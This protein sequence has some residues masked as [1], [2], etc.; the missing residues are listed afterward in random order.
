MRFICT[1]LVS[2]IALLH[3]AAATAQSQPSSERFDGLK[4]VEGV[5]I[6][7][8]RCAQLERAHTAVWVEAGG[9]AQCLRYYAF[10]LDPHGPNPRVVG[11]MHGDLVGGPETRRARH[12]DGLGVAEMIDRMQRLSVRHHA[13]FVFIARPGAYGSSGR[14]EPTTSTRREAALVGAQMA[15]IGRRYRIGEW[16]LAGHSGGGTMAAE[17][18]NRGVSIGCL[19]VSS[20]APAHDVFMRAA[21]TRYLSDKQPTGDDRKLAEAKFAAALAHFDLNPVADIDRIRPLPGLRV[22]I[23]ADPRDRTVPI[24]AQRHYYDALRGRKIDVT[25]VQLEKAAPPRRHSLVDHAEVAAG[26]CAQRAR[27]PE[28]VSALQRMPEQSDRISN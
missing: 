4:V 20:G 21:W 14:H 8:L 10:G 2:A 11:W 7:R 17:M 24:E 25:F 26:M 1:L 23:L 18:L 6:D 16:I 22:F 9:E 12:Q 13:P 3:P 15:A 28:I 5:S 19:I 27:T